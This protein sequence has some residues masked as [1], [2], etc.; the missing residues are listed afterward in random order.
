[1]SSI[2]VFTGPTLRADEVAGYLPG[3]DVRPPAALGDVY[4][5][6]QDRP[7]AIALI[8]GLF[9]RVPSPWHKELR[10]HV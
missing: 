9:D 1:M 5:A 6:M 4:R 10:A 7:R 2:V 8:D 3:A